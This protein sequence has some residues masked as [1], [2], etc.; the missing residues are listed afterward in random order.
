MTLSAAD[1]EILFCIHL[2]G[3]KSR[4][5]ANTNRK[6]KKRSKI[7]WRKS[8]RKRRIVVGAI[9]KSAGVLSNQCKLIIPVKL[10]HSLSA[11]L[12]LCVAAFL[13]FSFSPSLFSALMTP[14][15]KHTH[16]FIVLLHLNA[17]FHKA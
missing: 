3:C 2:S 1:A 10:G 8:Q 7:C 15:P 14:P 5:T 13:Q 11:S 4:C 16:S 12:T 17:K 9:W 6:H